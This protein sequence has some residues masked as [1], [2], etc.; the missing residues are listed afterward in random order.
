[1][2]HRTVSN[3]AG[4]K[5]IEELHAIKERLECLL[6]WSPVIVYTC[7]P[8]G[9]YVFSFVSENVL[10]QL[11]YEPR[12]FIE[13]PKFWLNHIHP[14]EVTHVS[15]GLCCLFEK[16]HYTHEYRFLHKN[17]TYRW[18]HDE[19]R[20]TRD[21]TGR[22]LEIIG[23]WID[24]TAQ[25]QME[26]ALLKTERLAAVGEMTAM[27][28]HDLRN[29]LTG[30][31]GATYQLKNE[32][33][34]KMDEKSKEMLDLVEK[35]VENANKIVNDLLD[36]SAEIRLELAE[37][38]LR[39]V[40]EQA[41]ASVSIPSN[42]QLT[43]LVS[44]E[45]RITLDADKMR[46]V[47]ENLIKNAVETMPQGGLLMI[48]SRESNGSLCVELSD[49][50]SGISKEMMP[51]LWTPF[52]TTRTSGIGLGLAICRRVV[53]AHNGHI[54]LE[55]EVGKGTTFTVTLP[56]ERRELNPKK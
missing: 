3:I 28:A 12:E 19:T 8:Y 20:L 46:R 36:Y 35:D 15:G 23:Y 53:E 25:K 7:E 40:T 52:H 51:K 34:S 1:M 6:T 16:D 21:D 39:S 4:R 55:S 10:S 54:S 41:L 50:G 30:I 11:G 44:D 43:N 26:E 37:T 42:I 18:I 47:F 27:L 2:N 49:T 14:E 38:N 48:Q 9:D 29:P 5:R 32:L 45:V 33:K 24:I 22:P 31:S 56:L 17:G 13:D